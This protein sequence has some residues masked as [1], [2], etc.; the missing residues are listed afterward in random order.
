[1]LWRAIARLA[2]WIGATST[3]LAT[4]AGPEDWCGYTTPS[5]TMVTDLDDAT[6]QML[7]EKL[8][9]FPPVVTALVASNAEADH[10]PINLKPPLFIIFSSRREFR[11]TVDAGHFGG[12]IQSHITRN[13]ILLSAGRNRAELINGAL[14]EYAHH[15]LRASGLRG[16]PLWYEEGL[17]SVAANVRWGADRIELRSMPSDRLESASNRQSHALA[18]V[19]RARRIDRWSARRV[20]HFYSAAWL[21]SRML[22]F[23]GDG[24]ARGLTE[25][26]AKPERGLLEV[27]DVSVR[28]LNHQLDRYANRDA[29]ARFDVPITPGGDTKVSRRCLTPEETTYTIARA[30]TVHNPAWAESQLRALVDRH[31]KQLPFA[32]QHA[33]ALLYI[34]EDEQAETQLRH[35]LAQHPDSADAQIEL[36]NLLS[37]RCMIAPIGD[38]DAEWREASAYYRQALASQPDR[39]DAVYGLGVT[40]LHTG[41]AG[42]GVNYLRAAYRRAPWDVPVNFYLG[43]GYRIIGDRRARDYLTNAVQWAKSDIWQRRATAALAR[44]ED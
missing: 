42:N 15:L 33:N 41:V 44:L 1:M 2:I 43:E 36:A 21:L 35:L 6:A 29:P 34:G 8:T 38:C 12:F 39:I 32:V 24:N 9:Q 13:T 7:I 4:A 10:A 30:V 20:E 37:L 40:I 22:H 25:F 14:H 17:V 3:S 5:F 26:L 18:E 19:L 23:G 11:R 31:P 28:N 16:H 27:L